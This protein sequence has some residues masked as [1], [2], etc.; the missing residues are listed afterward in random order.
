MDQLPTVNR[1][2]NY[3]PTQAELKGFFP[4]EMPEEP[5][6]FAAIVT[7]VHPHSPGYGL[8]VNLAVFTPG[9]DLMSRVAV[10]FRPADEPGPHGAY[11]EWM[12]YQKAVQAGTV[13]PTKHA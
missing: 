10:P 13:E 1:H 11:C 5:Q 2:V 6:P 12:P 8:L 3:R 7:Y 9:G 4:F